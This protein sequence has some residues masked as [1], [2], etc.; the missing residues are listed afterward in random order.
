MKYRRVCSELT[1]RLHKD[2]DG[3]NQ[4]KQPKQKE[5]AKQAKQA[6]IWAEINETGGTKNEVKIWHVRKLIDG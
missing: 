6:R 2:P 3:S 4:A 1:V 5:Q